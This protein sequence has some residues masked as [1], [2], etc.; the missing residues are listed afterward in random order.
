VS[1]ELKFG[2][3]FLLAGVGLPILIVVIWGE[4]LAAAVVG[5]VFVVT[6]ITLLIAGH[7]HKDTA[8]K[9]SRMATLGMFVFIG[10]CM[11]SAIGLLSGIAFIALKHKTPEQEGQKQPGIE[12]RP[13]PPEAEEHIEHGPSKPNSL[14]DKKIPPSTKPIPQL[15]PE[16][17][18][19]IKTPSTSELKTEE[20]KPEPKDFPPSGPVAVYNAKGGEFFA[21]CSSI[22]GPNG[23]AFENYGKVI[24]EKSS[25]NAPQPCSPSQLKAN[26]IDF[27][28][29][30]SSD[31][32]IPFKEHAWLINCTKILH[33][34]F[35]EETV[36]DFMAQ[37]SIEKKKEFLIKLM[38]SLHL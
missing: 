19:P 1:K 13:Q 25:V 20:S 15:E 32:D 5:S 37:P 14:I 16:K 35:G 34:E 9:R 8:K 4:K 27:L 2:Y 6:G 24:L 18:Q 30:T 10:A 17:P 23:K 3:G 11:G 12:S 36:K 7:F 29:E 33:D 21:S 31:I 22:N 26:A 28:L 38:A